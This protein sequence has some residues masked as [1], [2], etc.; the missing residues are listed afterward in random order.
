MNP[1]N[2][3]IVM[4]MLVYLEL[5]SFPWEHGGFRIFTK[6]VFER[7]LFPFCFTVKPDVLAYRQSCNIALQVATLNMK[8]IEQ[9]ASLLKET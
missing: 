5:F 3:T 4:Q 9:V 8:L 7:A 2:T 1:Q 6:P